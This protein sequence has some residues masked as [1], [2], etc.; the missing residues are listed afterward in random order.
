MSRRWENEF[1]TTP[2]I[3][4]QIHPQGRPCHICYR[5]GSTF[6]TV[7]P[8]GPPCVKCR[9]PF[10]QTIGEEAWLFWRCPKCGHIEPQVKE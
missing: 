5:S 7:H 4:L 1:M 2:S 9:E 10:M 6:T 8:P 3:N